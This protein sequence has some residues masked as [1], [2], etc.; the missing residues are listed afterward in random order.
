M[1]F[2]FYSIFLLPAAF[3]NFTPFKRKGSGR[4]L[5]SSSISDAIS[6]LVITP[7]QPEWAPLHQQ[8]RWRAYTSQSPTTARAFIK[9]LQNFA[10]CRITNPGQLSKDRR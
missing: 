10:K 2:F 1:R 8:L 9:L 4:P 5:A 7:S 6:T 3:Q